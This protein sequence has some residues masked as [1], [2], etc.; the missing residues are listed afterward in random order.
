MIAAGVNPQAAENDDAINVVRAAVLDVP[1]DANLRAYGPDHVSVVFVE[2]V[3]ADG[4]IGTGFTYTFGPGCAPVKSMVDDVIAPLV[5]GTRLSE[6]EQTYRQLQLATRRI[7]RHVFVPAISAVD[8]AAWDLRGLRAGVPLYRLLGGVEREVAIYG[9]GRS[10]N[11]L[12]LTALTAGAESYVSDGYAAIKLRV[13]TRPPEEDLARI[14]AIRNAVGDQVALMIDCNERLDLATAIWLSDRAADLGVRWIEEPLP[15][16]NVQAYA[17]L[18]SRSRTPVATGEHLAS[19][20]E[21]DQY[22]NANAAALFQPDAALAGGL[23]GCLQICRLANAHGISVSLHSLL[24]LH[25]QV[26]TADLNVCYVEHFPILDEIMAARLAPTEGRISAPSRPGHGIVWDRD[27]I[28]AHTV[29][30]AFATSRG[31]G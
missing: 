24:E 13:G 10:A 15:A 2:M 1:V 30:G 17:T 5:R 22:A 29:A 12:P 16:E 23:T 7:G 28:A 25:I 4:R 6:W 8:I 3:D 31:E 9:S 27:A 19:P 20:E 11:A 14:A 26:A 21:F 18:A